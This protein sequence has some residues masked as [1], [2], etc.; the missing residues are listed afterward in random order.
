MIQPVLERRMPLLTSLSA[1]GLS[2][3]FLS[4]A[5]SPADSILY[6]DRKGTALKTWGMWDPQS[7]RCVRAWYC[8]LRTPDTYQRS[9][10]AATLGIGATAEH[11]RPFSFLS[12]A[13]LLPFGRTSR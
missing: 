1:V 7:H 9:S 4:R 3:P 5:L 12:S 11:A 13:L 2:S 8:S 10:S 6:R